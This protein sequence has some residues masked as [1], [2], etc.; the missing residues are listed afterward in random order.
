MKKEHAEKLAELIKIGRTDPE[1]LAGNIFGMRFSSHEEAD[2]F[3]DALRAALPGTFGVQA[4][5]TT[6]K[7]AEETVNLLKKLAEDTQREVVDLKGLIESL[8]SDS[9]GEVD[10]VFV[11]TED[12]DPVFLY[13]LSCFGLRIPIEAVKKLADVVEIINKNSNGPKL[14]LR[15]KE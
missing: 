12:E 13:D 1:A 10:G 8:T 2:E 3:V 6:G 15:V 9:T 4:V 11:D 7:S 5:E 14:R